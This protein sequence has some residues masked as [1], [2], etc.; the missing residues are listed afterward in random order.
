M[1]SWLC[2]RWSCW[3]VPYKV[4]EALRSW[5]RTAAFCPFL[6]CSRNSDVQVCSIGCL[7]ASPI[8][9]WAVVVQTW[10]SHRQPR[11]AA[12]EWSVK[13]WC[14]TDRQRIQIS[15]LEAMH[16]I[17]RLFQ[18]LDSLTYIGLTYCLH[19]R[20][21]L[22]LRYILYLKVLVKRV[23]LQIV[24]LRREIVNPLTDALVDPDK[25]VHA[26]VSDGFWI[27]KARAQPNEKWQRLV[28]NWPHEVIKALSYG[29][30]SP[31]LRCTEL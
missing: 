11:T 16:L 29:A 20:V 25:N 18:W 15:N 8:W 9:S 17:I 12:K 10:S 31:T 1:L 23:V 21:L 27:L 22:Y 30:P 7:W 2:Y 24:A 26:S 4:K 6:D 14:W 5:F 3:S 19:R 28:V 13:L